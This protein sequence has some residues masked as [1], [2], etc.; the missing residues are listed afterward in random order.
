MYSSLHMVPQDSFSQ[1]A[2][3]FVKLCASLSL[4]GM[5]LGVAGPFLREQWVDRVGTGAHIVLLVDRSSSMNENFS[6]RY[7][8]GASAETKSAVARRL[9][10]EFVDRRKDDLMA[11]VAFSAAP[12]Y[13]LPLTQDHAA[14][15]AAIDSF[16]ERGHGVTNIGSGLVMA[17]DFFVGRP[18]TGSRVILLVSD[19]AARIDEETRARIGQMFTDTQ[20]RLHWIYLRNRTSPRLAD[21]PENPG[22]STSP[23]YFL[24]EYFQHL[25]VPYEAHEAE[26]PEALRDAIGEIEKLTNEPLHYQQKLPR[27]DLSTT[28]YLA[29][30]VFLIPVLISRAMEIERWQT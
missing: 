23:E 4:L 18:V 3:R 12:I 5:I 15:L 29:A 7:L 30:L 13:V 1:I 27:Q 10:A 8:G 28:F 16:A 14:V 17:L 9:L 6:G 25:D 19:G 11:V 21:K 24:H 2:D 26:N 20:A 22:E